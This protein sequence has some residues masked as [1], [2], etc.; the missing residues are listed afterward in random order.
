MEIPDSTNNT[1]LL[2][3]DNTNCYNVGADSS[4][5]TGSWQWV[6]Y[7]DGTTSNK[8]QL[9][10]TAGSHTL[11][12]V[13]TDPGVEIDRIMALSDA[14]CTPTGTGTNCEQTTSNP[15]T[16]AISG[17]ASSGSLLSKTVSISATATPDTGNSISQVQLL[18]DGSVVQT[19]TSSPYSF[20]LNTLNYKDGSHS[21]V[22]KATDNQSL[23]GSST[24][25][26]L[27]TNGDLNGD[28]KVNISDLSVM[29]A[30]WG[31]TSATAAQGDLNGDGKVNVSD[32]SVLANNWQ[33]SW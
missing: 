15:P 27:I 32:L 10:L 28:R 12:F 17:G 1:I 24:V 11:T 33:L 29:A 20:S 9:S 22:V 23:A 21:L 19:D 13:G 25:N 5:P 4:L 8:I 7:Y 3:V 14:T 30:N 31:S 2:K 26:V 16:T 18:L 6:N